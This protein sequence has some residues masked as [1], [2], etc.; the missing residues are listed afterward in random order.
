MTISQRIFDLLRQTGQTQTALA[1]AIG[2]RIATV[3]GWKNHGCDPQACY[4]SAIAKFFN[5]TCDF[6]CTGADGA[7]TPLLSQ[8]QF[9][10]LLYINVAEYAALSLIPANLYGDKNPATDASAAVDY[11]EKCDLIYRVADVDVPDDKRK[12][13]KAND[14]HYR[15]TERG[16]AYIEH[17]NAEN[18]TVINKQGIFGNGNKNNTVTIHGN[19]TVQLSE[20]ESELLRVYSSLDTQNKTALLMRAYELSR[21]G[22][23]GV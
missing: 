16:A 10:L 11:L 12:S 21:K 7:A 5:V 22:T 14:R 13:T 15:V 18:S 23:A 8:R 6:I 17:C 1:N 20:F 4:I 2:V 3:T 9:D 19:G